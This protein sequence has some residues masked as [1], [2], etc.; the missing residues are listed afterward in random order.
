MRCLIHF[1]DAGCISSKRVG[2]I[3]QGKRVDSCGRV[4]GA[5]TTHTDVVI[6]HAADGELY[7]MAGSTGIANRRIIMR[8][9]DSS[10][11]E[12]KNE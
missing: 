3:F 4:T 10:G 11:I 12:R 5:V 7:R 9:I 6:A 2:G 1:G 8:S